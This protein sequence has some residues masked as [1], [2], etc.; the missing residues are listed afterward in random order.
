MAARWVVFSNP[1]LNEAYWLG[2][3]D[4]REGRL[5]FALVAWSVGSVCGV[6]VLSLVHAGAL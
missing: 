5:G 4:G 3:D 1:D 6:I 2:F